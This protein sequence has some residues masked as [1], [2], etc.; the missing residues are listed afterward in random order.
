[1][2]DNLKPSAYNSKQ[3]DLVL[4]L[5]RMLEGSLGAPG[6]NEITRRFNPPFGPWPK[7]PLPPNWGTE[8]VLTYPKRE[9][10]G[11]TITEI[12][13]KDGNNFKISAGPPY[14]SPINV[15]SEDEFVRRSRFLQEVLARLN[16]MPE[17]M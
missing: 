11:T 10:G 12:D 16:P 15:K 17:M 8:E 4:L 3:A 7:D 1:M 5:L 2:A 14:V 6:E 13:P 9:R